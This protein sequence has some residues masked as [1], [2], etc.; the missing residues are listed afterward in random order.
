M[1]GTVGIGT[2]VPVTTGPELLLDWPK[3]QAGDRAP[4]SVGLEARAMKRGSSGETSPGGQW[5][6]GTSTMCQVL[7]QV[8][9]IEQ[10]PKQIKPFAS[11]SLCSSQGDRNRQLP[12]VCGKLSV[13]QGTYQGP[14]AGV[15]GLV[16]SLW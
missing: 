3:C 8:R 5:V 4:A 10:I 14:G 2:L 7:L 1:Q 9:D 16:A 13:L 15:N 11:R 12:M 6:L